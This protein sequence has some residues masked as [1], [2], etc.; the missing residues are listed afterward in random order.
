MKKLFFLA[1]FALLGSSVFA[2]SD[3]VPKDY[4]LVAAADYALY[5]PQV[6]KA[7][8]WLQA[9]PPEVTKERA[10]VSKFFLDWISGS[11]E[12]SI[13]IW[14][15][16]VNFTEPNPSLL[17]IFTAGWTKYALE[18]RKFD[19]EL[20]GNINGLERVIDY[21]EKHGDHLARDPKVEAYAELY[22]Q[23]KL[24]TYVKNKLQEFAKTK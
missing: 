21:Y 23:K 1:S 20:N 18:T 5:E 7:I 17:V 8:D 2:Q 4:K 19:D 12:V 15:G 22:K 13:N 6:L 10:A 3:I 11:P 16:I 24:N 9:H 14:E